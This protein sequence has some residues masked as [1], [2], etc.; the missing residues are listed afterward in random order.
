LGFF[1]ASPRGSAEFALPCGS[2]LGAGFE[3]ATVQH[4][5]Y[6][7]NLYVKAFLLGFQALDGR[8]ENLSIEF[9]WHGSVSFKLVTR[10]QMTIVL[11]NT[12]PARSNLISAAGTGLGRR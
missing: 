9:C 1:H 5:P 3:A 12:I 8:S 6:L 7:A 10:S 2:F 11:R 4:L